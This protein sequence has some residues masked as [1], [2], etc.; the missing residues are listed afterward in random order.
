MPE[1]STTQQP[2]GSARVGGDLDVATTIASLEIAGQGVDATRN[3][4][5][6]KDDTKSFPLAKDRR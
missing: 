6:A 3:K 5:L 4:R 2:P 1:G